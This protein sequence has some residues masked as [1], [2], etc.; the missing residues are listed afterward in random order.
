MSNTAPRVAKLATQTFLVVC[1]DG[2]ETEPLRLK[3]LEGHLIYI[4]QNNNRYRVA[5]PMRHEQD[6]KIVGSLFLVEGEGEKDVKEFLFHDPYFSSQMYDSVEFFNFVPACGSWMKGV[7][8][9]R[10]EV[11][12]QYR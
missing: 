10:D 7:I 6:G 9:D 12:S 5:G 1:K 8:W 4:E 11:M 3:H 2:P